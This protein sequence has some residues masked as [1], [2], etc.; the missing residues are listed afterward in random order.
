AHFIYTPVGVAPA[1]PQVRRITEDQ[2]TLADRGVVERGIGQGDVADRVAVQPG[3]VGAVGEPAFVVVE[4]VVAGR[5]ELAQPAGGKFEVRR[6]VGGLPVVGGRRDLDPGGGCAVGAQPAGH[7]SE[8]GRGR[9]WV[10]DRAGYLV[11][12]RGQLPVEA[13]GESERKDQGRKGSEPR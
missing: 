8:V 5:V 3:T 1:R 11:D 2:A 6:Q 4:D 10:A 12:A 13:A 9:R 7:G